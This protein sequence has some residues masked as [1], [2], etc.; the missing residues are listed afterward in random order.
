[1][2]AGEEFDA[3]GLCVATFTEEGSTQQQQWADPGEE[4]GTGGRG[5]CF[6]PRLSQGLSCLPHVC[7]ARAI[8]CFT[9]R[10]VGIKQPGHIC[11]PDV[12]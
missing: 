8:Q 1:V 12:R 7:V 9:V 3:G 10:A 6:S 4:G 11:Q 2:G 5:G